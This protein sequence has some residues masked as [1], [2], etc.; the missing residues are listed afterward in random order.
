MGYK[1]F[2]SLV[3][4][5]FCWVLFGFEMNKDEYGCLLDV[6]EIFMLSFF[7]ILI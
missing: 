6:F 7:S 1:E 2:W 5:L 4:E 3:F